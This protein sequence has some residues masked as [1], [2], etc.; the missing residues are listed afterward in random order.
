[1]AYIRAV[2][3]LLAIVLAFVMPVAA[4]PQKLG[5][6]TVDPSQTTVSGLSAG[7]FM[8]V[9][10][11]IA[12][13]STVA[14]AGIVAGGPY[15][16][17]QGPTTSIIAAF[18]CTGF[19][20]PNPAVPD[21]ASLVSQTK[22]FAQQ[23]KIDALDNLAKAK[24]YLFS[25][26]SDKTVPSSVVDAARRYFLLAGVPASNVEYQHDV[27]AGHAFITQDFGN[28]CP[29]SNSP[30][31]NKCNVDQAGAI[32]KHLYG[33]LTPPSTQPDGQLIQFDQ[34]DFVQGIAAGMSPFATPSPPVTV[35]IIPSPSGQPAVQ[36]MSPT[37]FPGVPG[38][39]VPGLP[40]TGSSGLPGISFPG[41]IGDP[42]MNDA[43][44]VYVPRSCQQGATCRVHIAFHGGLQTLDDIGTE[45]VTKTGFNNWADTNNIIVLY[46][47][48]KKTP[49]N[50]LQ[51]FWDW[52]GYT[53]ADYAFKSSVQMAAVKA[54]LDHLVK[55]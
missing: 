42:S 47:Q 20:V 35:V 32:L 24:I 25:G 11:Q 7:A 48:T 39:S 37:G 40:G 33:Q 21:P 1:M 3:V 23:G 15:F 44:Y 27:N 55:K 43:G 26:L 5:S 28:A 51:G 29:T 36:A 19:F 49:A 10:F 12:F 2:T 22:T 9:Q 34:R 17:A 46:P 52:W 6:Y 30:Y 50:N 54:M 14:G 45:Y 4:Q 53:G 31:I 16:C 38:M 41:P 18:T 13:S 8:A